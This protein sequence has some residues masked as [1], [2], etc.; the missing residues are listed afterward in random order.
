VALRQF[1]GAETDTAGRRNAGRVGDRLV[2]FAVLLPAR[3]SGAVVVAVSEQLADA[4]SGVYESAVVL[5]VAGPEGAGPTRGGTL[6]WDGEH[7]PMSPGCAGLVV[8]DSRLVCVDALRPALAP[9]GTLAVLASRGDYV[10]Y[11]SAEQPEHVWR[12]DWPLPA[13]PGMR[14]QVRRIV[15]VRLSRLRGAPYLTV[16]GPPHAALAD[17]V[18]ADLAAGIGSRGRLV[19]IETASGTTLRLR[20]PDG[21]VAVRLSLS[22]ADPHDALGEAVAA[23]VPAVRPLMLPMLASGTTAGRPWVATRWLSPDR[24]PLLDVWRAAR[25]RRDVATRTAAMLQDVRTGTTQTGWARAWC[26][27]TPILPAGH[28]DRFAEAMAPLDE[29]VPTGWCHGDLWSANVVLDRHGA[30]VIDWENAAPNA[31]QGL[32]WLLIALLR[33]V[34]LG[35]SGTG[36]ACARMI[37]GTLPVD[38]PVAGRP[39][40]EW[41]APRRGALVV[42]AYLLHLRNR[43]L[44]DMDIEE[45]DVVAEALDSVS[46]RGATPAGTEPSPDARAGR[47]ARGAVWL[48][49]GALSVKA[50]QTA[51]L[52][53]LA[54]LLAPSAL[55]MIAIATMITN[56]SQVLTDLGTSVALVYVRDDARRAART[57][58]SVA[59]VMSSL[60]VAVVWLAAPW[61]AHTLHTSA[62]AQWVIRGLVCVLPCYGVATASQ[63]L[64]RRDLAFVRRIVPDVAA[65]LTGAAI[66]IYLALQGHGIAGLVAGQIVQGVMTLAL[67]W[68]VAGG[69]IL[70]G[71]RLTDLRRLLSY[72][73]HLTVADLLQLALLNIDYILVARVLGQTELGQ[74]SLAFRLAYLPY[75]NVAVVISGAAFPY[76]CRLPRD[77][78]AAALERL[79]AAAMTLLLPTCAAIALFA[80][81]IELLGAKWQPAV[82]AVRWLALYAALLSVSQFVHVAANSTGRPRITM[83]LQLLHFLA[84]AAI[85]LLL[86]RHGVVAVAVG[87]C[88][89]A[90]IKTGAALTLARRHIPGL[91]LRR[92]ANDLGPAALGIAVMAVVATSLHRALPTT[93]VSATGLVFVGALSVAAYLVPVWLLGRA[94]LIRTARLLATTT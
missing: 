13:R 47:A 7:S 26:D 45:F 25:R 20:R 3:P 2:S 4:L 69:V 17:D 27:A 82:A 8:V 11:P 70:P 37:R 39:F 10:I 35:R 63:E 52:L 42:A 58:V 43:S 73:S 22:G 83:Q 92:L 87:Q 88:L 91:S 84:L 78:V 90:T 64:V 9:G 55:G 46:G 14:A 61:I 65:A 28:R 16:S 21:D 85:L 34:S 57:S 24:G 89:A 62:D 49:I 12:W 94:G 50:A 93:V 81:Q 68:V 56:V 86:V 23:D 71:F 54:A 18:V 48:G 75:L 29:G 40:T 15:G 33:E 36:E 38:A 79:V 66:T 44:H 6:A 77:A 1:S 72:G 53:V 59:L 67:A 30:A 80:D 74:Y 31:P 5:S 51:L 19:G 76:L 32:D 60:V 41:D